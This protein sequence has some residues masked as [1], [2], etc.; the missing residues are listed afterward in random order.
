MFISNTKQKYYITSDKVITEKL[1]GFQFVNDN[2]T[3]YNESVAVGY[4][5][6]APPEPVVCCVCV[7]AV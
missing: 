3:L 5:C 1:F 4:D 7:F 6:Q 2:V